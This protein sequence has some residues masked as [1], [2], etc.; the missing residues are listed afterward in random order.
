MK[1]G[2]TLAI[3]ARAMNRSILTKIQA[4]LMNGRE[5]IARIVTEALALGQSTAPVPTPG[6][7]L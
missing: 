4:H 1:S 3:F 5:R 7:A 6:A 2:K